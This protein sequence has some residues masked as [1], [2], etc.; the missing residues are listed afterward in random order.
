MENPTNKIKYI[1]YA[2]KSSESEEKQAM[3]IDS[4]LD[5][6]KELAGRKSIRI[7]EIRTEAA[8]AK[9]PGRLVF[10]KL[11]D[12]IESGK[13][14]GI[15]VWNPD[16]LSRN[17]MD[18]GRLIYLLDTGKLQEIVTPTQTFINT[19]NDKF[20][21]NLLCGQTKFENDNKGLNVKRGLKTKCER[22]IYPAPAPLG[23]LNDKYAERGNKTIQKDPE[24]F[25]L[26][27]K[28]FDL[29]LTG[30]YS[31]LK[32]RD[33][34]NNEWGFKT[35]NG[36][37]LGRSSIYNIFTR[38]FYYGKFEYPVNSGFWYKGIHPSMIS[39][40]EYDRIQI[41][42]GREGK[43]RPKSHIFAFTGIMRCGECGCMITA[44]EKTKRQQNG[45]THH[46]I[47]YH[48]TKRK[49]V[50]CS[51]KSIEEKALRKQILK[52]L[53]E[54]EVHPEFTEWALD[55]YKKFNNKE[56]FDIKKIIASNEKALKECVDKIDTLIDMRTDKE[57]S[58]DQFKTKIA[59]LEK[60]KA[61]LEE[62]QKDTHGRI[63]KWIEKAEEIFVLARDGRKT[64]EKGGL[65]KRREILTNLGSHLILK[66]KKLSITIE[67]PLLLMKK[68]S[69]ELKRIHRDLEPRK[70]GIT[71]EQLHAI[72]S[73]SPRLLR[74]LDSNQDTILQRDVSYH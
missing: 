47:Y 28:M 53:R 62:L 32:I 5:V 37:K 10:T 6:L 60:D 66:D 43:P 26:I 41:L 3:S 38:P 9:M 25:D 52:T 11:L 29:M 70:N 45:N 16:R 44:E 18:T 20:L 4:Q 33:V 34:A 57:I 63:S 69:K 51:Q 46:Y 30:R 15:I 7:S 54:I 64:F 19:P 59:K 72:Y 42:L 40:E 49:D 48:C 36:Q 35:P 1:L 21:F 22:G 73:Q 14:E 58:Q 27:R 61:R 67:K 55:L 8:S 65:E 56:A 68:A 2:R 12:D 31:P 71:K 17:S 24:C 13:Y 39:V 74:D 50:G 23:Y